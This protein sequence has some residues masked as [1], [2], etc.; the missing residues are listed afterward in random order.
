MWQTVALMSDPILG[1]ASWAAL[2]VVRL[3]KASLEERWMLGGHPEYL[4]YARGSK[5]FVPCVF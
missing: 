4:S 1:W 5:R 3:V 2:A